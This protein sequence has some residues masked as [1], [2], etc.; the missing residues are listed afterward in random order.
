M[1]MH[2][3]TGEDCTSALKGKGKIGLLKKMHKFPRLQ[4]S[5]EELDLNWSLNPDTLNEVEKFVCAIYGHF[6]MSNLLLNLR[7]Q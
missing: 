6:R 7:N 3:F 1:G 4:K 2:I 5:F